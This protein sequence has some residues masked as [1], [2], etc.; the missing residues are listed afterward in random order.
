MWRGITAL[1]LLVFVPVPATAQ[2]G[3]SAASRVTA[4][5]V[6]PGDRIALHFLREP[7]LSETLEVNSRGEAAFPKLG[8]LQVG[9]MTIGSLVDTLRARYSEYLRVPELEIQVLRRVTVNGE[10]RVPNVY[11]VDG[12]ATVRDVIAQAGGVT[13][14]GNKNN[15]SIV[16]D[17][18]RI[19]VRDWETSTG[20]DADLHSGDQV[21]VGRKNWLVMNSLSVVS[22]AVLVTSFIL[23]VLKK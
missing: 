15:V 14:T 2:A 20:P 7:G 18:T 21:I 13:E 1:A 22:T 17:G 12:A 19:P 4:T 11:L 9:D 23:S 10:V 16:R 3:M 5:A 6:R 8:V